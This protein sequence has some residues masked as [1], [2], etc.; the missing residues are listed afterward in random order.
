MFNRV[1]MK[2]P[3]CHQ[4]DAMS[5]LLSNATWACH[6]NDYLH[7]TKRS[8]VALSHLPGCVPTYLTSHYPED[9]N[10]AD[11]IAKPINGH[12]GE[13]IFHHLDQQILAALSGRPY[14]LQKKVH[15]NDCVR[16]TCGTLHKAEVRFMFLIEPGQRPLH[17]TTM[18]RHAK[19]SLMNGR[20]FF[21]DPLAGTNILLSEAPNVTIQSRGAV[22]CH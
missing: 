1:V 17:L 16:L 22:M 3:H 13:G 7:F 21:A 10:P 4:R 8:L 20:Q 14:V 2:E 9:I 15:F 12:S 11:Y 6:P 18:I 5:H 19:H